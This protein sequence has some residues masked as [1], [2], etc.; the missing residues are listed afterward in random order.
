[1]SKCIAIIIGAWKNS[2]NL[3]GFIKNDNVKLIFVGPK[4]LFLDYHISDYFFS[5]KGPSKILRKNDS[6]FENLVSKLREILSAFS[7][8]K[9]YIISFDN[10]LQLTLC[11]LRLEFQL[12]GF[13]IEIM[14]Q[15]ISIKDMKILLKKGR[16]TVT[17]HYSIENLN[18]TCVNSIYEDINNTFPQYPLIAKPYI[19]RNYID[20]SKDF[21]IMES[22]DLKRW[23]S[24]RKRFNDIELNNY[25][26]EEYP[27]DGIEFIAICCNF[28]PLIGIIVSSFINIPYKKLLEEGKPYSLEILEL[29]NVR[30]YYPGLEFFVKQITKLSYFNQIKELFFIEGI[31][32]NHNEIYFKNISFEINSKS[33]EYLIE[34]ANNFTTWQ[35]F[36][37]K[38]LQKNLLE[39]YFNQQS[40]ICMLLNDNKYLSIIN[41]PT[42]NGTILHQQI[43][44]F[45]TKSN[46]QILWT[47][48]E[49]TDM[50]QSQ[51]E[52]DNILQIIIANNNDRDEFINDNITIMNEIEIAIDR[53]G[54]VIKGE[55][56]SRSSLPHIQYTSNTPLLRR[57]TFIQ[58]A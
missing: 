31:Y 35:S 42:I 54:H 8:L 57:S 41:F 56:L 51:T 49:G 20:A 47:R 23:F 43:L 2:V 36:S 11:K 58:L 30:N 22:R 32:K 16:I 6:A 3:K 28:Q 10:I 24:K 15:L 25:I 18:N 55:R 21:L 33:K 34:Q 44:K 17:K 52:D 14:N 29:E 13:N 50:L 53:T 4:E 7:Y 45:K 37:L 38:I 40:D 19:N 12:E 5:V 27:E 1:M 46:L 26:L 48:S 39:E 9:R